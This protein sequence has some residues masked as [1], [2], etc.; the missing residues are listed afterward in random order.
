VSLG[1]P[2]SAHETYARLAAGPC[3]PLGTLCLA[4]S[5]I[6]GGA[7]QPDDG[8]FRLDELGRRLFGAATGDPLAAAQ[9]VAGLLGVNPSF[10]AD[11]TRADGLLLDTVL[12]ERQG[13]PLLLA[14]VAA[15]AGRRAGLK[16]GVFSSPEAW[17][18]GLIA[19]GTL[20]LVDITGGHGDPDR[21]RCRGHC[22]HELAFAILFGLEHR[23][24]RTGDGERA[25]LA[26][27]LR[28][29][30]RFDHGLASRAS[31]HGDPLAA[32]WPPG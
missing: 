21:E 27:S 15:E 23:Y 19:R 14:V 12:A 6:F 9:K 4:L 1:H 28:L 20:W 13:H 10:I 16:T 26:R 5:G 8:E 17:Y 32:L 25:A 3:P 11:E 24:D 29:G 18:A 31:A 22:G 7:A 30:L 2:N